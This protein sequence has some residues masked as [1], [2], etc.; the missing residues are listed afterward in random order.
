MRTERYPGLRNLGATCYIN[1]LLQQLHKNTL[2]GPMLCTKELIQ[3]AEGQP[4]YQL[5]RLM[6]L[7]SHSLKSTIH[8]GE[9]IKSVRFHG[10]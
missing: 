1:S 2:L 9:F 7:L 5:A 4:L 6:S 3:I 8:P 10:G